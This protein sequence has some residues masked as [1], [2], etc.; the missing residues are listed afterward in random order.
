MLG[1]MCRISVVDHSRGAVDE[2]AGSF[3]GA[4]QKWCLDCLPDIIRGG[5]QTAA[6]KRGYQ[7][8]KA[9]KGQI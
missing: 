9:I 5:V 8:Q 6:E 2:K 1:Q 4:L 3:L 7:S